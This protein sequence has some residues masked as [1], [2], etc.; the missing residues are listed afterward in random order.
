MG[1]TKVLGQLLLVEPRLCQGSELG[2]PPPDVRLDEWDA[3]A[4][5]LDV[6]IL[7]LHTI[8]L[9]QNDWLV[10]LSL[11]KGN[12]LCADASVGV[13]HAGLKVLEEVGLNQLAGNYDALRLAEAVQPPD[14]LGEPL[15]VGLQRLCG[16]STHG[17]L[18]E[19]S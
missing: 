10:K 5:H 13:D 2:D 12:D 4:R 9:R 14:E 17:Q 8:G 19:R 15:V 3:G 1:L 7:T 11:K 18:Q 16:L 6:L